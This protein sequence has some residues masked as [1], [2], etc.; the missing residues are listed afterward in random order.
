M[1]CTGLSFICFFKLGSH[2]YGIKYMLQKSISLLVEYAQITLT[3][4][5]YIKYMLQKKHKLVCGIC[6]VN[7]YNADIYKIH[8]TE[9]T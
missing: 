9:K 7:T 6:P 3:M 4:L 5:A 1:C 8:A 2:I